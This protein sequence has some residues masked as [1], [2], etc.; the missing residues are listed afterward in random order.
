M[1]IWLAIV[2]SREKLAQAFCQLNHR[3]PCNVLRRTWERG[4]SRPINRPDRDSL[5]A[6]YATVFRLLIWARRLA[7]PTPAPP[8]PSLRAVVS[9]PWGS[10]GES[11]RPGTLAL[12]LSAL[13]PS[14]CGGGF[15][16]PRRCR[17]GGQRVRREQKDFAHALIGKALPDLKEQISAAKT[18]AP[19]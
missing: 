13:I 7:G 10:H 12:T 18:R 1:L 5:F 16:A 4:H 6:M 2:N 11:C 17:R 15:A 14:P 8:A 3:A 9:A 19:L